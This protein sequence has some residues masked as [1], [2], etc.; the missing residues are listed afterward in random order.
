MTEKKQTVSILNLTG[1]L[2][3]ELS[4]YFVRNS[5]VLHDPLESDSSQDFTHILCHGDVDY[6]LI[7]TNYQTVAKDIKII[8]LTKVRDTQEFIWANGKLIFDEKWFETPIGEFILDKFFLEFGGIEIKDSYPKFQELGKFNIIN[9]FNSGE[10]TD[11]MVYEAYQAEFNGL[12]VKTYFDHLLMYLIS[13]KNKNKAGIPFEVSY[14]NYEGVFAL[15]V[16]FVITDLV[17]SDISSCLSDAMSDKPL[18]NVLGIALGSTS[19]FEFTYLN[20]VKKAVLTAFWLTGETKINHRGLMFTDIDKSGAFLSLPIQDGNS[21]LVKETEIKDISEK[22]GS[23]NTQDESIRI[24]GKDLNEVV[25]EKISGDIELEKVKQI[26]NGDVNEEEIGQLIKGLKEE[27]T[28]PTVISSNLNDDEK[29]KI[30]SK[31][32][33]DD[34]VNIVKGKIEEE[35]DIYLVKGSGSLD[36]DNFAMRVASGLADNVKGDEKLKSKLFS[37]KLPQKIKSSLFDFAKKLN[38]T[39]DQIS[40]LEIDQFKDIVMPDVIS[41]VVEFDE[42]PTLAFLSSTGPIEIQNFFKDFKDGLSQG[43]INNFEEQSAELALD[44]I[45]GDSD[46]TT[47]KTI[48]K[49][50]LQKALKDHFHLEAKTDVTAEDESLIVKTLST[51]LKEDESKLKQIFSRTKDEIEKEK[52][53]NDKFIFKDFGPSQIDP[54]IE[55]KLRATENDNVQL[56]KQLEFLK[57]ELKTTKEIAHKV[58][59]I[60]KTAE[61]ET[62]PKLER[63]QALD[64]NESKVKDA[65]IRQI[66]HS[67]NLTKEDAQKL[68]ELHE[69]EKRLIAELRDQEL[70]LKKIQLEATQKE[71]LFMQELEKSQRLIRSK[72]LVLEKAKDSIGTVVSRKD[73]EIHD[74]KHRL[75]QMTMSMVNSQ[76][77]NNVNLVRD[78]ERKNANLEKMMDVYKNKIQ[79]LAANINR[80]TGKESDGRHAEENRKL[81][82]IKNQLTNQIDSMKRDMKRFEDKSEQDQGQIQQLRKEAARLQQE[83]KEKERVIASVGTNNSTAASN[84]RKV[85]Y[86]VYA[87]I[88]QQLETKSK[89]YETRLRETESKLAEALKLAVSAKQAPIDDSKGKSAQLEQNLKRLSQEVITQ[90]NALNEAKKESNKLRSEKTAL[91]NQLDRINKEYEKLKGQGKKAA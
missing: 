64:S 10:Y 58:R 26:I 82:M 12:Q 34:I 21:W 74:L 54:R 56:K 41:E 13:L 38:K 91:Q 44:H 66:E 11:V 77:Q 85:D 55:A 51:T 65:L 79:S 2:S 31:E 29:I 67:Q 4:S 90:K 84:D 35:K 76:S 50:S 6:N 32:K 80:Q 36:I 3:S 87:E 83:L 72:E 17:L 39:I 68:S 86:A 20:Q 53:A 69:K 52:A 73:Q 5:I 59:T 15:Q 61:A 62:T 28:A 40:D 23:L 18:E 60:A 70:Y 37:D 27:L 1:K 30:T 25:A 24:R 8:S 7:A 19:F 49:D 47:V 14:G 88:Q 43:I 16:H 9:P 78:L 63:I 75:D 81:T 45:D 71:A 46:L 33:F 89:D 48:V 22:V 57:Q 42:N